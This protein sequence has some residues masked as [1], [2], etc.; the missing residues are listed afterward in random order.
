[1]NIWVNSNGLRNRDYR[2]LIQ[3][4]W[5]ADEVALY[6]PNGPQPGS[7]LYDTAMK[8]CGPFINVWNRFDSRVPAATVDPYGRMHLAPPVSQGNLYMPLTQN[9]APLRR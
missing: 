7:G 4:E 9:I 6:N 2:P 3:D 5:Y 1:M 8:T